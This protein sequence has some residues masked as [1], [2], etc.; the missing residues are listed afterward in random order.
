MDKLQYDSFYKFMVSAGVILVAAPLAGL[1]YLLCNGNQVLISQTEYE[2]LSPGS[3]LFVQQRDQT[4]YYVLKALP[5]LLGA[6]IVIGLICLFYGSIKWHSIQKEL[7]EQTRLKTLE[8][9]L[10]I[11][12]LSSSEVVEKVAKEIADDQSSDAFSAQ[13]LKPRDL[14]F[15]KAIT[16]ENL[17]YSYVMKEKS[18][19]YYVHQNVRVGTREYDIIAT[20]KKN[21]IDLLYEIKYYLNGVT[22]SQ[23]DTVLARIEIMGTDYETITH[24]NWRSILL[25]V[26][27][28]EMYDKTTSQCA[29][30]FEERFTSVEVKVIRES[31]LKK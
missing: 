21:N 18:K 7:D 8:Q 16:I 9:R 17:C 20:S 1:Y 2:A 28:D 30:Y 11:E 25:I 5:W 15:L 10:N 3:Q 23:L 4:I 19:S 31:D 29:A 24:R 6:L 22:K 26:T 27:P 12:Q 14:I 13:D